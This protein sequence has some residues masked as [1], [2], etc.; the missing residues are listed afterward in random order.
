VKL[1]MFSNPISIVLPPKSLKWS[2]VG[3]QQDEKN[4]AVGDHESNR[5]PDGPLEP[6]TVGAGNETPIKQ[7]DRHFRQAC[8]PQEENLDDKNN[9]GDC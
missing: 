1:W 3:E 9:L 4:Y 7:E 6:P 8:T 2:T 5:R